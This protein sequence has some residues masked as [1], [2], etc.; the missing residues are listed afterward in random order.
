M[1]AFISPKVAA[2]LLAHDYSWSG[3]YTFLTCVAIMN[4]ICITLGFYHVDFEEGK[5]DDDSK[6]NHSELSKKAIL[7]KVTLVCAGYILIYVGVEVTLGGWGFTWLTEGRHGEEGPMLSVMSSY[8]GGL[9][10]GRLALGYLS[11]RFGEKLMITLFT[12][13]IISGLLVMIVS[14]DVAIDSSGKIEFQFFCSAYV[15]S[16]TN[17]SFGLHRIFIR[18][19]VP[20]HHLFSFKSAPKELPLYFHWIYG[21]VSIIFLVLKKS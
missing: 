8:W 1:G 11:G 7:N 14:T 18:P 10:L 16:K 3:M 13:M 6:L 17:Y 2:Y 5:H 4:I 19:N 21:C 20:H 9:A 15:T 12:I